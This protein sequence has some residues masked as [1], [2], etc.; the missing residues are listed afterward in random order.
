MSV[1][2]FATEASGLLSDL[3]K[4]CLRG[5][6]TTLAMPAQTCGEV[7]LDKDRNPRYKCRQ[8]LVAL[9]LSRRKRRPSG[10][11]QSLSARSLGRSASWTAGRLS[12][13]RA[14]GGV[15]PQPT[16]SSHQEIREEKPAHRSRPH[17]H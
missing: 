2:L 14:G 15:E 1:M 17:G 5:F 10:E 9:A 6:P 7:A 13:F 11:S 12:N 3:A 16:L 4:R 8:G